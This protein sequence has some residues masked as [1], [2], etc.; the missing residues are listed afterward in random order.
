[1]SKT[2]EYVIPAEPGLKATI[3]TA[4]FGSDREP[5]VLVKRIVGW[6][7][8]E[9]YAQ[10]ILEGSGRLIQRPFDNDDVEIVLTKGVHD[11]VYQDQFDEDTYDTV[12]EA[13]AE[14]KQRRE[15]RRA[16]RAIRE[17]RQKAV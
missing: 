6:I 13:V 11:N 16:Y 10:P 3:I 12:E 2:K 4:F 8:G 7:V 15:N 9:D 1:M 5:D 17:A 14:V